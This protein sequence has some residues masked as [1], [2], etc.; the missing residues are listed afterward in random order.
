V[1][2]QYA[3]KCMDVCDSRR[4]GYKASSRT[5]HSKDSKWIGDSQKDKQDKQDNALG[6]DVATVIMS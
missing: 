6:F 3:N 1:A 5:S 4:K 2:W